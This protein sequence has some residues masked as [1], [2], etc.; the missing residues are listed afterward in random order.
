MGIFEALWFEHM[1]FFAKV[2][3]ALLK[4]WICILFGSAHTN[5][6]SFFM[7][8]L[9]RTWMKV[10]SGVEFFNVLIVQPFAFVNGVLIKFKKWIYQ[11]TRI[12]NR[13]K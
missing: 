13:A 8:N 10:Q 4:G 9:I 7:N 6:T 2:F 3:Y 12:S 1:V 11:E 5:Q